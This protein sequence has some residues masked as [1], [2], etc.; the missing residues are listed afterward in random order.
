VKDR[1]LPLLVHPEGHQD[2]YEWPYP[3]FSRSLIGM[4]VAET[5]ELDHTF[6]DDS[7]YDSLKNESAHFSFTVEEVKSRALPEVNDEFATTVGEYSNLEAL[8]QEIRQSLLERKLET[9]HSEYD[10]AVLS[11]II[12]ISSVK[13]PPQMLQTEIEEMIHS[14]EHRLQDQHVDLDL[15]LKSRQLD[16]DGLKAEIKPTAETRIKRSLV[17]IQIAES[18]KIVV[19]PDELQAETN[20]AVSNLARQLPEKE[21]KRFTSQ[22]GI[23][24][25]VSNVM[26]EMMTRKTLERIRDIGSGK[27][28]LEAANA[29][30]IVEGTTEEL[31]E[32]FPPEQA[33]VSFETGEEQV[34]EVASPTDLPPAE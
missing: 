18:E 24:N 7:V 4:S 32:A 15:Y 12:E 14:L 19:Q 22:E 27:I 2:I 31:V 16:L 13:Y 34:T 11:H 33:E 25:L 26:A 28:E 1:S 5:Q 21:L 29:E 6:S 10:E 17:L 9:Y 30:V 3:G 8:M 23:Q 20:R